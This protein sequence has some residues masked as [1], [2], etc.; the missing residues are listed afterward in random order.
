MRS[1]GGF[2]CAAHGDAEDKEEDKAWFCGIC[3]AMVT[4]RIQPRIESIGCD[5]CDTWFCRACVGFK[6]KHRLPDEWYCSAC[7]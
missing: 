7:S 3:D 6:S 2:V 4:D 5:G 1:V